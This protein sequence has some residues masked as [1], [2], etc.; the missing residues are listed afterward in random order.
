MRSVQ[1]HFDLASG[2]LRSQLLHCK[3]EGFLLGVGSPSGSDVHVFSS[4]I[5]QGHAYSLLQV[6]EVDGHK[7]VKI[8][9]PWENEVE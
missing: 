4:G 5:F 9:N 7:L 6:H 8:R 1:A 2:R 3:Q